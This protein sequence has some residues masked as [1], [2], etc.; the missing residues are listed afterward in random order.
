MSDLISVVPALNIKLFIIAPRERQEKVMGELSRPTFLKIGL[1]DFCRF[2]PAEDLDTLL[3]KVKDL[4]GHIQPSIMD[5][6]A[7]ELE[8]DFDTSLRE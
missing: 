1:S 7:V 4:E 5:T 3:S 2:I 8:E 6:I